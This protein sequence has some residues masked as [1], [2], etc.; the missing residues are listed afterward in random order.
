MECVVVGPSVALMAL[1]PG[2]AAPEAVLAGCTPQTGAAAE[3]MATGRGAGRQSRDG[4]RNGASSPAEPPAARPT[5]I[6]EP[7]AASPT[8]DP[9]PPAARP[10][11]NRNPRLPAPPAT[12]NPRLPAPPATRHQLTA[13]ARGSPE[14]GG[15]PWS[16]LCR[17]FGHG[18]QLWNRRVGQLILE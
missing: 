15:R 7:P 5:C 10:A 3:D 2:A 12:R 8:C 4:R 11:P 18:E 9:E 1:R 13:V 6:T 14:F 17:I 16:A